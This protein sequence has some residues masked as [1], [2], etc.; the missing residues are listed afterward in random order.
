MDD[1]DTTVVIDE[2]VAEVWNSNVSTDCIGIITFD[3]GGVAMHA[4]IFNLMYKLSDYWTGIQLL[5]LIYFLWL[6]QMPAEC[7]QSIQ[8]HVYFFSNCTEWLISLNIL[9]YQSLS[10]CWVNLN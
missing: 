1:D 5:P 10:E 2:K 4:N 6:S 8:R 3:N 9:R 7:L